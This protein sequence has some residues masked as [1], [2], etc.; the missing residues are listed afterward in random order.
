MKVFQINRRLI[1]EQIY[2]TLKEAILNGDLRPGERL[3]QDRIAEQFGVS[4]MPVRDALRLLE[5][6]NLVINEPNK[7]ITV[8]EFGINELKDTFFVRSILEKEAIKLAVEK[9]TADKVKKLENLHKIMSENLNEDNLVKLTKLNYEFHFT[10]YQEIDSKR[11]LE[12]IR[13]LWD[14]YPRYAM[15][16]TLKSALKSHEEH[17]EILKAIKNNNSNLASLKMEEHILSAGSTYILKIKGS[18]P[19]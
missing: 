2:E 8:K 10:I 16:S 5:A 11:L 14:N 15:L 17:F 7:G 13:N 3:M 9:M 1:H 6:N 4:R 18:S 12:L 19:K